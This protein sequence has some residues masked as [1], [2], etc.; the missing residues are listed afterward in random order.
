MTP[1]HIHTDPDEITKPLDVADLR[2]RPLIYLAGPYSAPTQDERESNVEAADAAARTVLSH[3][4]LP[5]FTHRAYHR[6]W[7]AFPESSFIQLGL[8]LL[9]PCA[10]LW[11]YAGASRSRASAGTC[12]EIAEADRVGLPWGY[13][14]PLLLRRL[15]GE[16]S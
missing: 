9:R 3:G 4:C 12:G 8:A 6:F 1:D 16:M 7:G 11:V 10:A 5:V 14:L 2:A 13:D 15:S